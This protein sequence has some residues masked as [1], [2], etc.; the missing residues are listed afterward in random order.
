MK[1]A[2]VIPASVP[3]DTSCSSDRETPPLGPPQVHP[4]HHLGPSWAS[5]PP[6]PEWTWQTTRSSRSA[7]PE[8]MARSSRTARSRSKS[9]SPLSSSD[10]NDSSSSSRASS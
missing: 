1:V 7:T 8:Y 9:A 10:S 2:D 4:Q 3:V 6:A 5:V